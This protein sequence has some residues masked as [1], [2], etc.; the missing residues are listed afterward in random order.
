MP[1]G[2][3]PPGVVFASGG[4]SAMLWGD[5]RTKK[6][7]SGSIAHTV[8]VDVTTHGQADTS[9]GLTGII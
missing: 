5:S 4:V 2:A 7:P 8:A 6:G 9:A 1:V 3:R